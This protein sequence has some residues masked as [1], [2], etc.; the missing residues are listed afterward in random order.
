MRNCGKLLPLTRNYKTNLVIHE[1]LQTLVQFLQGGRVAPLD[2]SQIL[3]DLISANL[4]HAYLLFD[5]MPQRKI[6][7]NYGTMKVCCQVTAMG[8]SLVDI[9]LIL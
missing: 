5:H 4:R 3:A 2:Q 7:K 8:I 1:Q 9:Q 6:V